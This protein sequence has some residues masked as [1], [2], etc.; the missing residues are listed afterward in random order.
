MPVGCQ[1]ELNFDEGSFMVVS[2]V[3]S[4]DVKSAAQK[5]QEPLRTIAAG[6]KNINGYWTAKFPTELEHDRLRLTHFIASG[7]AGILIQDAGWDG[8][9]HLWAVLI[10]WTYENALLGQWALV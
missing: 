9:Q 1:L 10:H 8:G 2:F 7:A 5:A 6:L 4:K 3:I